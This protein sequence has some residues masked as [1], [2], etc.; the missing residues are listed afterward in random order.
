MP[1]Q[2]PAEKARVKTETHLSDN[3]ARQ[4]WTGQI[5]GGEDRRLNGDE[6]EAS[7]GNQNAE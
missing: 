4:Q 2:T 3:H 5:D 1:S 7:H 6:D